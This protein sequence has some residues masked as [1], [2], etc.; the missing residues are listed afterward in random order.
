MLWLN[1]R[2]LDKT[3]SK[4]SVVTSIKNR[5]YSLNFEDFFHRKKV[6]PMFKTF[7]FNY[8]IDLSQTCSFEKEYEIRPLNIPSKM[9]EIWE[10]RNVYQE[11]QERQRISPTILLKN[12]ISLL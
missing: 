3:S 12:N 11:N 10:F 5:C 7:G 6:L 8:E 9:T 1:I 4:N 2:Y